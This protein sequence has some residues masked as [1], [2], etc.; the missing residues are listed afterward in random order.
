[1]AHFVS[2]VLRRPMVLAGSLQIVCLLISASTQFHGWREVTAFLAMFVP[3][4]PRH[5][6]AIAFVALTTSHLHFHRHHGSPVEWAVSKI[7]HGSPV[8]L[9]P[10][11]AL[12][13]TIQPF[14]RAWTSTAALLEPALIETGMTRLQLPRGT[15]IAIQGHTPLPNPW[16]SVLLAGPASLPETARN[17][18]EWNPRER[19]RQKGI[20][21]EM[22]LNRLNSINEKP[23]PPLW[24][25]L[26]TALANAIQPTQTGDDEPL[27]LIRSSLLGASGEALHSIINDFRTTG[28]LHLFA[29]SGMNIAVLA[30]IV[31][32]LIRPLGTLHPASVFLASLAI[33][34]YAIATGLAP[35]CQR[36]LVMALLPL[37]ATLLNRPTSLLDTLA[38]AFVLLLLINPNILFEIGFQLS[39]ALVVGLAVL[40]PVLTSLFEPDARQ[41]LVPERLL[42]LRRKAIRAGLNSLAAAIAVSLTATIISLPWSILSFRQ[43]AFHAPLINLAAVP[44]ANLQMVGA[45]AAILVAP[46]PA[47][48]HRITDLNLH[49]A[50]L[51]A[52]VVRLGARIP[53]TL[54]IPAPETR[55]AD[56]VLLDEPGSCV[57]LLGPPSHA[58]LINTGS[59][60][61]LRSSVL[62]ALHAFGCNTP[63]TAVLTTGDSVHLGGAVQLLE[64]APPTQWIM[65]AT[66]DR[67]THHRH[68]REWMDARQVPKR[69]LIAPTV[70]P[71]GWHSTLHCLHPNPGF[72]ATTGA[73]NSAVLRWQHKGTKVLFTGPAGFATEQILT[74]LDRDSIQADIWFKGLHPRD[75]SGSATLLEQINPKVVV[76]NRNPYR[77]GD[78]SIAALRTL[79]RTRGLP[80]LEMETSGAIIG[81]ITGTHIELTPYRDLANP[82]IIP[83]EPQRFG[84]K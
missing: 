80:L 33:T 41:Q 71:L 7:T 14:G 37:V 42:S 34:T 43:I 53:A 51:L 20:Q 68:L 15:L 8:T 12:L 57:S 63:E 19:L 31:Q 72:N 62:P 36:A 18:G 4:I 25:R 65:P 44:I 39:V 32:I 61:H 40:S 5:L 17:P 73:D 79:C 76:L 26:N 78:A 28:T 48:C 77:S 46:F 50:R 13:Q 49:T 1:M 84:K 56:F 67:S 70:F 9:P 66:S 64:K 27:Q 69:F 45:F 6:T 16:S 47:L 58:T 81:R 75:I 74:K 54:L 35:S 3:A 11:P 55:S 82:L 21:L 52:R 24:V 2:L 83:L 29:V 38:S 22:H 10:T 59:E 30:A 60:N 23:S